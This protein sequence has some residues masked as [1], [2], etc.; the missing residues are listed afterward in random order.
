MAGKR[1]LGVLAGQDMPIDQ[2]LAW[3]SQAEVILA[4]DGGAN[5]LVDGGTVPHVLVGDLDSVRPEVREKI[6]DVRNDPDPDRTDVDK[7]L[8]IAAELHPGNPITLT[9]AEGDLPDH[10][11][12]ALHSAAKATMPVRFA[13]RRGLGWV[14]RDGGTQQVQTRIGSRVSLIPLTD[15]YGIDFEGVRWPLRVSKLNPQESTSISNEALRPTI[16]A[17]VR[18]GA[19]LLFAEYPPEEMPVW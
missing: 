13:L 8:R 12:A 6:V 15:C 10:F 19:C 5:R 9:S 18:R 2:V 11:I 4:A 17:R 14:I 1:V 16:L 7:L 3:A